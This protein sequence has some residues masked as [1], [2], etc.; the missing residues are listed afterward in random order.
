MSEPTDGPVVA[1]AGLHL[2]A[3]DTVALPRGSLV[4]WMVSAIGHLE[5]AVNAVAANDIAGLRREFEAFASDA[6]A[7]GGTLQAAIVQMLSEAPTSTYSSEFTPFVEIAREHDDPTGPGPCSYVVSVWCQ[8]DAWTVLWDGIDY[9][10]AK[11]EAAYQ[12]RILNHP[13]IDRTVEAEEAS[14]SIDSAWRRL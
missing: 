9:A 2:L 6:K 1:R 5:Q 14:A 10:Q 11:I 12:A 8:E 7:A 4:L 13:I 3:E